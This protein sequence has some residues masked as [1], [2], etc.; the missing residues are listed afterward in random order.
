[1]SNDKTTI[2]D[3]D[4]TRATV[5]AISS[6]TT[7][8]FNSEPLAQSILFNQLVMSLDVDVAAAATDELVV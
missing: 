8:G 7:I 4:T 2:K 5:I 3:D 1:M 6:V